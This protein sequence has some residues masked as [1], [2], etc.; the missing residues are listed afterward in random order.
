MAFRYTWSL[1]ALG[2]EHCCPHSSLGG[3]VGDTQERTKKEALH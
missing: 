3:M 1:F 2:R